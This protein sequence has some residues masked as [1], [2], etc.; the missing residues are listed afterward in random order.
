MQIWSINY[1]FHFG[2]VKISK[3]CLR[4]NV[5]STN[6]NRNIIFNCLLR[7]KLFFL[8]SG[9]YESKLKISQFFSDMVRK[10]DKVYIWGR[11]V[12]SLMESS[13]PTF[14]YFL[15]VF[16]IWSFNCSSHIFSHILSVSK[17]CEL[18]INFRDVQN[19]KH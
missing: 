10:W 1:A 2:C 7:F 19:F 9:L 6:I 4:W 17:L 12:L 16:F 8:V 14:L 18:S 5:F 3:H 13:I 15:K 11:L